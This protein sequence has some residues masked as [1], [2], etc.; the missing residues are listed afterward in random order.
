MILIWFTTNSFNK[1]PEIFFVPQAFCILLPGFYYFFE[2][3]KATSSVEL[4]SEPKFWIMLGIMLYFGCTL[5]LFLLNNLLDFS[6]VF[7]RNVFAINSI[8]YG[9]LYLLMIKAFLCKKRKA[10]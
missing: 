6:N 7:E 4:K 2:I 10:L 1:E 5:P 3:A 9:L 8:C